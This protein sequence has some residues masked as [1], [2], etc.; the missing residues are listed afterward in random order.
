MNEE[1]HHEKS[2]ITKVNLSSFID[3]LL[4]IYKKG[5]DYVDILHLVDKN[6]GHDIVGLNFTEE[7]M[8][9]K[10]DKDQFNNPEGEEIIPQSMFPRRNKINKDDINKLI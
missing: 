9:K 5:V 10:R 3:I 1:E 8:Y 7:Y 6:T 4:N 2:K